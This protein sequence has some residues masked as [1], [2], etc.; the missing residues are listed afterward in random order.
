MIAVFFHFDSR[1]GWPKYDEELT[2]DDEN[3]IFS[4]SLVLGIVLAVIFSILAVP[5]SMFY[6]NDA[7]LIVFPLL[8]ISILFSALNM[9]PNAK[10]MKDKRFLKVGIRTVTITIVTFTI[11]V[12][13]AL[14][15]AK[16]Y[17][18][19]VQSILAA[20]FT[21]FWNFS[22]SGLKFS[23]IKKESIMKIKN[24]FVFQFAYELIYYLSRNV[25]NMLLGRMVSKK[26]LQRL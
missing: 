14:K 19:V 3:S 25:D 13:L 2:K 10:L 21:F 4:F 18:L 5:V 26:Q 9:V 12:V 17:S 8:S 7:F 11:A 1:F 22:G 16:Y 23:K 20:V 15:G 6:R 24:F